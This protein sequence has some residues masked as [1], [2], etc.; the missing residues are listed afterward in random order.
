MASVKQQTVAAVVT[1]VLLV[2][3]AARHRTAAVAGFKILAIFPFNGQSHFR[4][5]RAVSET[6]VARGHNVT[7][8]SHFPPPRIPADTVTAN[9]Q[10]N[11]PGGGT[12]VHYSLAGT[13]PAFENFTV[14]EMTGYGY[15]E[16]FLLIMQDGLDNC[17]RVVSSGR[18]DGLMRSRAEFDLVLVEVSLTYAVIHKNRIRDSPNVDI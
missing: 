18:L 11:G 1:V 4:V 8:V 3:V 5:F 9:R 7:V 14:A 12:F 6:L 15:L 17:E 2:A 13:M 10:R 16:R